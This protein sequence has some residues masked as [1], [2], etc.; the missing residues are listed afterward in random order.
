MAETQLSNRFSIFHQGR[1]R[2]R[3]YEAW[4]ESICRGFCRLDVGPAG[5][6]YIDCHNEFVLLDPIAIATPRGQSARFARTRDLLDD[7]C[8]D[9]VL[10]SAT[11]GNVRVTQGSKAIDLAAGQMCLTEMN[12]VGAVDLNR[13]GAFTTTRFPRR[14]LLQVAPSAEMQLARTLGHDRALSAMIERYTALCNEVAGE[15]DA[16]GQKAAAQHLCDLAGHFIETGAERKKV[17]PRGLSTARLNLLKA[18]ILRN[19]DQSSL[20]IETVARANGLSGRQAQR[21]FAL[22]GTTFTDFVLEQRLLL[23]RRL[24]LHEQTYHRKVSDIALSIGFNDLSYFN[25]SFKRRF[26]V[27]PSDI[28]VEARTERA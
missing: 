4:R 25:R 13:T 18:D 7:G 19:L 20:T 16:F 8:D 11:R 12:I 28:K 3:A 21:L 1:A 5:D 2:G 22:S 17:W 9:L 6:D 26:G 10:I 24:L 14:L 15:L 27:T 23:A